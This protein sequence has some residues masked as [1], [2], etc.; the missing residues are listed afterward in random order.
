MRF[1]PSS[2]ILRTSDSLAGV[3]TARSVFG[4]EWGWVVRW[5]GCRAEALDRGLKLVLNDVDVE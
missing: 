3:A 2:L 1:K 5:C 4:R